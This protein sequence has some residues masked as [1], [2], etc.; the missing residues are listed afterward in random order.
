MDGIKIV[1]ANVGCI[2]IGS[3]SALIYFMSHLSVT[4]TISVFLFILYMVYL[5]KS[6]KRNSARKYF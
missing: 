5:A 3:L 4:F 1:N 2:G 6:V